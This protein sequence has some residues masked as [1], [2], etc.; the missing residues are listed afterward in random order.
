[1]GEACSFV[2]CFR[3]LTVARASLSR[4]SRGRGGGENRRFSREA[5]LPFAL[6]HSRLQDLG[7]EHPNWFG[8]ADY[9]EMVE[10]MGTYVQGVEDTSGEAVVKVP[11]KPAKEVPRGLEELTTYLYAV[12]RWDW[13]GLGLSAV[14]EAFFGGRGGVA[15]VVFVFTLGAI[16]QRGSMVVG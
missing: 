1:M 7:L 15:G 3:Q 5:A 2:P 10:V 12:C 8:Y 13:S 4:W 6:R 14:G 16:R 11:P 9:G